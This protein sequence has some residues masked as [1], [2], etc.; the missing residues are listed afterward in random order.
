MVADVAAAEV[1]TTVVVEVVAEVRLIGGW[2][3]MRPPPERTV[4]PEPL[5]APSSERRLTTRQG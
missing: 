2:R 3:R 1:L 5:L 4:G